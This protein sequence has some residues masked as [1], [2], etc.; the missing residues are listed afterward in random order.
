MTVKDHVKGNSGFQFYRKGNLHYKT[1]DTGLE[2][3]V[4]CDPTSDAD[5]RCVEKSI[6]LMKFI[7]KELKLQIEA[8]AEIEASNKSI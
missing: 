1:E 2:F 7:S 6:F 4:P 5:F 3:R 8:K